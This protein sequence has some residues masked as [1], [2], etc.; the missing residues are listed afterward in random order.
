MDA[1]TRNVIRDTLSPDIR[2]EATYDW[3]FAPESFVNTVFSSPRW[4][5]AL[6]E[7]LKETLKKIKK[8]TVTMSMSLL[9]KQNTMQG[10]A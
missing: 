6:K 10:R 7:A 5:R 4:S 8:R 9:D 1:V 2:E 3:H